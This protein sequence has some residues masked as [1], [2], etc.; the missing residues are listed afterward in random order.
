MASRRSEAGSWVVDVARL[1]LREGE[2]L[3]YLTRRERPPK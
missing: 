3:S 1:A 2:L